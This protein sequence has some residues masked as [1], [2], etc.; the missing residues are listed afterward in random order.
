MSEIEK[1][2]RLEYEIS[3]NEKQAR[4][5]KIWEFFSSLFWIAVTLSAAV[6]MLHSRKECMHIFRLENYMGICIVAVIIATF[7]KLGYVA[8]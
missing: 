4:R 1:P 2:K 6:Y 8:F 7:M 3:D 5:F